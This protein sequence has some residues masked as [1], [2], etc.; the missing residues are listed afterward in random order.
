MV[1]APTM[2]FGARCPAPWRPGRPQ[3]GLALLLAALSSCSGGGGGSSGLV[4]PPPGTFLERPDGQGLFL[5]DAHRGGGAQRL[6]LEEITW[7]RLVDVHALEPDGSVAPRPLLRDL[8]VNE[9]I[10]TD[11]HTFRLE[12]DAV[13]DRTRLVVM[14][15]PGE[16]DDGSGTFESLVRSAT[17]D[18]PPVLPRSDAPQ[19]PPP[20]SYVP[21]NA[22]LSLRFN[23]LLDDGSAALQ[24][25]AGTVRVASGYP[26]QTPREVRL[27]FDPGHGGIVDGVFHSTRVVVDLTVSS[28]EALAAP[29]PL[30]VNLSGLPASDPSTPRA[31]ASLRLPTEVDA[32]GGSF[33]T[34]R[35]LSGH[36]LGRSAPV[37][38]SRPTRDLVRAFRSGNP[39][40]LNNGFLLDLDPPRLLGSWPCRSE[41]ARPRGRPREWDMDVRFTTPCVVSPRPREVL[42]FGE[43][44]LEVL[45]SGTGPD[46]EGR[47][48][49]IGVRDLTGAEGS[50]P[51]G[52]G[53][54]RVAYHPELGVASGCWLAFDPAPAE[55]P[56]RAVSPE[57][58]V[59]LTFSEPIDPSSALPFDSF[60]LVRGNSSTTV[61]A[62]SLIVGRVLPSIDLRTF[63]FVPSTVLPRD[64]EDTPFTVLLRPER[65]LTDLA[66]NSLLDPLPSIEFTLDEDS[67]APSSASIV[68]RLEDT[69]EIA[70]SR[71]DLRGNF[72]YDLTRGT[73]R[74]RVPS[75][76]SQVVDASVAVLGIM[77]NFA[78]GVATPLSPL[79]S[80]LMTVWRYADL[81]WSVRDESHYDLDVEGLC[82]SPARGEIIADFFQEFEIRLGHSR[83]L[84]DEKPRNPNTGGMRYPASGLFEGPTPFSANIL[85]DERSPLKIVHPRGSGYRIRPADRFVSATGTPLIP[86]PMNRTGSEPV[87]FHWRD[88]AVLARAGDGGAGV[89]MHIEVSGPLFLETGLGSFAGPGHVPAVGLPLLMEFR[90]YPSATA[91]GLN[92]VAI[93]LASGASAAPNFR[94]YSTGGIDSTGA[95]VLRDPDLEVAPRGGFN[96][97]SRPPGR[98]TRRSADNSV[99]LGQ[100]DYAIS[101]SR[102]HTTWIDTTVMAPRFL[103]VVIEPDPQDQPPGTSLTVEFRGADGFEIEG[104]DPFD[105]RFLDPYGDR[106]EGTIE[107]HG[108]DGTWKTNLQDLDGARFIQARFTFVGD[109]STGLRP[110]L[111]ALG[112][113]HTVF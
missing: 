34:L 47:V 59:V 48:L 106:Q 42:I 105:A 3:P 16:V 81:G 36:P 15:V 58:S 18:L 37:D 96:P 55:P 32:S 9:N 49:G 31:S 46:P 6:L 53:T 7:G 107:F 60:S 19:T 38:E 85:Q 41:A 103:G 20:F 86:Y 10:Q 44:L 62:R 40:D 4:G 29:T 33:A 83:Q 94:A 68:L 102:V 35:S 72:T 99:Y 2:D 82:W 54:Y 84:P 39:S 14:R 87:T 50:P 45:E 67:P 69:D 74:P 25:L 5:A 91:L 71:S 65:G 112:V 111:S 17:H 104:S 22:A 23:D 63:T 76:A 113:V 61:T 43:A 95:V 56:A 101:I 52:N 77:P 1:E 100:L 88:T 51:L 108:G 8:V 73:I 30:L 110:E 26:P 109:P 98:P 75:R 89:P 28:S 12:F 97:G 92:P 70:P 66:G 11:E 64:G 24:E 79:G 21:R 93:N 13:T 27:L 78:P 90:C 57:A 80:R